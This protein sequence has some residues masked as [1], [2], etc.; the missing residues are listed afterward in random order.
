LAAVAT[1][2]FLY[3]HALPAQD[4]SLDLKN[5]G[6]TELA[7]GYLRP[8]AD[9]LGFAMNSGLSRSALVE[10]DFH[11][12]L[13][14]RGIWTMIPAS[15]K[16]FTA[17][18]PRE[19]WLRGYPKEV[20]T[21]TVVGGT[22]ATLPSQDPSLPAIKLPDGINTSSLSL[23]VPQITIGSIAHTE[24]MLRGLPRVTVDDA[25]GKMSFIGAGLKNN[26][27]SF[28]KKPFIDI[29]VMAV[30]QYM[31]V[32]AT[33]TQRSYSVSLQASKTISLITPYASL[34]YEGYDIDVAY[35]YEAPVPVPPEV[36]VPQRIELSFKGRNLRVS[37]GAAVQLLPVMSLL[38][39]YSFGV[40]D[41]A[42]L[43]LDFT[44]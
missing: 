28:S 18:L 5:L 7:H 40:Q 27:T 3:G 10:D 17:T 44:F 12:T 35:D 21:A 4:F 24:L 19:L 22:G 34:G 30:Y 1:G 43:G 20:T 39:E 37:A 11:L 9:A 2:V 42:V 29:A 13:G 38:A 36:E 23:V 16:T 31:D 15:E 14:V 26:F 41:N 33:M 25:V 32:N 8:G 6:A